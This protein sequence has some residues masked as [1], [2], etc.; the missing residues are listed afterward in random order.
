[1][2]EVINKELKIEACRIADLTLDQ[3][4]SFLRLWD[5][6]AAISTLTIFSRPDG[7]IVLNK[8]NPEYDLCKEITENYLQSSEEIRTKLKGGP[9]FTYSE[10]GL[11]ETIAVLEQALEQRRINK[12]VDYNI[13]TRGQDVLPR[14]EYEL[15]RDAV[16]Q[17]YHFSSPEF[18]M[19]KMIQFGYVYGKREERARRKKK[20]QSFTA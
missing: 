4:E 8:D 3:I 15:I 19:W 2:Y 17:H 5:D 13:L 20:R 10:N 6:G 18:W 7:T 14:E 9:A 1:M 16:K 11:K 12:I